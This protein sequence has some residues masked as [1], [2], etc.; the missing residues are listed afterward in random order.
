MYVCI[1]ACGYVEER[2]GSLA[3]ESV[4]FFCFC[5]RLKPFSQ[6]GQSNQMQTETGQQL[7]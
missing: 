4:F 3:V 2:Q 6:K 5:S 1:Q 7:E